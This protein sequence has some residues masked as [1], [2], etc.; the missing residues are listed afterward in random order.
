MGLRG[1]L[2][3]LGPLDAGGDFAGAVV[4]VTGSPVMVAVAGLEG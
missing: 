3:P 2:P 4:V 1:P